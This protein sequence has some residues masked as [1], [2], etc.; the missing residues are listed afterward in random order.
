MK[1]TSVIQM[2]FP[3]NAALTEVTRLVTWSHSHLQHMGVVTSDRRS[4]K[5]RRQQT[6]PAPGLRSATCGFAGN[7]LQYGLGS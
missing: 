7:L 1:L 3:G 5:C 2:G 6:A 4:S